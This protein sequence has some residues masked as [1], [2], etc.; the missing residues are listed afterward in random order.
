MISVDK[1]RIS[2]GKTEYYKKS[3]CFHLMG[4]S[5][6]GWTGN[7]KVIKLLFHK[8]KGFYKNGRLP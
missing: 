1:K 6:A 7:Q 3:G 4:K 5:V 2:A 8:E